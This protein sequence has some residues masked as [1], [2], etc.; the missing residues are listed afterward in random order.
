[1]N[2]LLQEIDTLR[3][4]L[5]T[6][7]P[8][9]SAQLKKIEEALF[10]EYTYESNRIEG[11][12]LTLQE[13]VLV[14][15]KGITVSGKSLREHLEAI[16]H[17]EAI[18]FIHSFAQRNESFTERTLKD[19]HALILRGIDSENAGKY[20]TVNVR[21]AG[22]RHI[23]PDA[24]KVQELFDDYFQF[25]EEQK[26]SPHPVILSAHIHEKLVTIHPFIDGNGKTARLVMN[27]ILLQH[28][29]TLVNI[30]GDYESRIKYYNALEKCQT[31]NTC[32]DFLQ[33]VAEQEL[34]SLT[35]YISIVKIGNNL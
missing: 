3:D 9:S 22:S 23:P 7:R 18:G 25:Y 19:I 4:E 33:L 20:R 2:K 13:T 28:G 24:F 17:Y 5:N 30:T 31:E 32:D 11:N 14:I 34:S 26:K 27:L 8:L 10:V 15:Q 16:N 21:I 29:Y 12:T 6:F 1:M 35:S